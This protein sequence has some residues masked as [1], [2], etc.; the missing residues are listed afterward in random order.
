MEPFFGPKIGEDQKKRSLL[1]ISGCSVQK[2]VKTEDQKKNL[3]LKINGFLIQMRKGTTKQSEKSKVIHHESGE[4][5]FHI[6]IWC[7]QYRSQGGLET[8]PHWPEK[9]AKLHVF[10]A[11]EIS[12]S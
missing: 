2:Y 3:C 12:F 7:H 6:I 11:F 10:K 4:L 8:P 1:Q 9:Y 5:W